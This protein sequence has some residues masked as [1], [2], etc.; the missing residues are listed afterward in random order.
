LFRQGIEKKIQELNVSD[1]VK[2]QAGNYI[3][4]IPQGFDTIL[5]E[6]VAKEFTDENFEKVLR[7]IRSSTEP[8]SKVF[9][10][11][12]AMDKSHQFYK[13]ERYVDVMLWNML[14]GRVRTREELEGFFER[15]GFR[16]KNM[17]E[18]KT[19]VMFETEVV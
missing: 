9:F 4:N 12:M 7:N 6:F 15:N 2:V 14:D 18:V 8:G 17:T 5:C 16:V 3:D 13:H 10:V 11:D 1:R 19:D